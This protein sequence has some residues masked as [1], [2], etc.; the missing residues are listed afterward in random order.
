VHG[1]WLWGAASPATLVGRRLTPVKA[2]HRLLSQHATVHSPGGTVPYHVKWTIAGRD[3]T[4]EQPVAYVQVLDA[5]DFA[6]AVLGR[7]PTDI[8]VEDESGTPVAMDFKIKQHCQAKLR[9]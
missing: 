6:C 7:N 8:W 9:R 1:F 4:L 3:E 2:D 5:M